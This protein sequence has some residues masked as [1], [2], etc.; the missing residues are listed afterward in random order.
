[1]LQEIE[2]PEVLEIDVRRALGL[3][4]ARRLRVLARELET[5][6][7]EQGDPNAAPLEAIAI[8]V[9]RTYFDR[10]TLAPSGEPIASLRVAAETE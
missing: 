6:E 8:T 5:I 3:P 1:M 2:I 9:Y 4:D 10:D 7:R